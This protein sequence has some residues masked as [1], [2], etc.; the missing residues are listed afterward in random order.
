M[1]EQ[2]EEKLVR[3]NKS[4]IRIYLTMFLI[5]LATVVLSI[6]SSEHKESVALFQLYEAE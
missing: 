6:I 4:L 2:A 5:G 1:E 3:T